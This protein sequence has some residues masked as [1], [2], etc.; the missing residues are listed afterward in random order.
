MRRMTLLFR[1]V[2]P[3]VFMTVLL[4]PACTKEGVVITKPDEYSRAFESNE[5]VV[6]KALVQVFK[7]KGFGASSVNREKKK[8]ES[9][10]LI[11]NGW[12]S[13]TI[14]QVKQLNWKETD[15]TLSVITEK[16]VGAGWEMRRLL[17]K[18][19]YDSIF[20]AIELQIYQEMYKTE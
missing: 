6:L 19:Q 3:F 18:E 12:R 10:Y 13:K 8:I 11:Q 7:D 1:I 15:V 2:L 5:K 14:A 20:D 4:L 17:Q 9:A 16:Q